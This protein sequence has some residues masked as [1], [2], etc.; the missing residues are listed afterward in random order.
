MKTPFSSLTSGVS[1]LREQ[2]IGWKNECSKG[3]VINKFAPLSRKRD[4]TFKMH[5]F[6]RTK[7][8]TLSVS[9]ITTSGQ[10]H[11]YLCPPMSVWLIFTWLTCGFWNFWKPCW[12]TIYLYL[13]RIFMFKIPSNLLF[14]LSFWGWC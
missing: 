2:L 13:K 8:L 3:W 12:H 1:H 11:L 5:S 9:M 14:W 4:Y 7:I 6:L 10:R